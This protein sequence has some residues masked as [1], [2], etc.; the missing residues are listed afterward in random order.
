MMGREKS[1][2]PSHRVI[3][4]QVSGNRKLTLVVLESTR[5]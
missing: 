3:A 5:A 4:S 2:V 1:T